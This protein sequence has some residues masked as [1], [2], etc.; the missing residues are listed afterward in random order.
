MSWLL[1]YSNNS[2]VKIDI[3]NFAKKSK[4]EFTDLYYR[5]LERINNLKN[6]NIN[7]SFVVETLQD[8]NYPKLI[9]LQQAII[10]SDIDSLND[11]FLD[12]YNWSKNKIPQDKYNN[13]YK[14][15][16]EL[17]DFLD[18]YDSIS[19]SAEEMESD[20]QKTVQVT[21]LNMVQIKNKIEEAIQRMNN[22]NIDTI[23]I[24]PNPGYSEYSS[25]E[26]YMQP[27]TSAVVYLGTDDFMPSFSYFIDGEKVEI[28]D[29][30]EGGDTDFFTSNDVQRDYFNLIRELKNPGSS[31][32][33]GKKKHLYTA[34]PVS[35]RNFYLNNKTIPNN[36]FLTDNYNDVE[37]IA[38]DFGG[39]DIWKV[40]IDERYLVQTLDGRIKHYQVVGDNFVPVYSISLISQ[41]D[42]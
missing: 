34:R 6:F 5:S 33:S 16:R 20:F 18:K 2:I 14:V 30:L 11:L 24:V 38:M 41:T 39:R 13:F 9:Q 27:S 31:Q 22:F 25:K 23:R 36:I 19:Y 37:G 8:L 40:V 26:T 35:D 28:D 3:G 21:Q 17:R 1:K 12:L 42:A 32:K 29:I 10:S 7:I 15:T 4:E